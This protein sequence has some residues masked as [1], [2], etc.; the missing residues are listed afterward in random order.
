[1]DNIYLKVKKYIK[2]H[3]LVKPG[4][5]M[6]LSLSAGK[7]SMVLFHLMQ[8]L[9][10]EMGFKFSIFHLNHLVRGADSDLDQQ[11]LV[12]LAAENKVRLFCE[13][14]DFKQDT[15]KGKSF[16]EYARDIRYAQLEVLRSKHSF[17]SVATAHTQNDN[18]ETVL[19]RIFSGTGIYGLK[20][21][22]CRRDFIIRPVLCL[23]TEE[24]YEYLNYNGLKWREDLSNNDNCYLRNHIRNEILPSIVKRF[25]GAQDS[26]KSLSLLACENI[27]LLDSLAENVYKKSVSEIDSIIFIKTGILHENQP[28]FKHIIANI[29]RQKFNHN[30]NQGMLNEIC[31]NFAVIR[32]N[33]ILYRNSIFRIEKLFR[34]SS[35]LIKISSEQNEKKEIF[36]WEYRLDLKNKDSQVL[37]L[38]EINMRL[39]YKVVDY[40]FF[41]KNKFDRSYIFISIN[42]DKDSILIRNRRSGDRIILNSGS[43]KIKDLLI[44]K[45][46]DSYTKNCVPLI[47]I[48]ANI[49]AYM[50]GIISDI[51][52]RVSVNFWVNDMSKKILAISK[53]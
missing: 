6:L 30:I 37:V 4:D 21:I 46:L 33:V 24:M 3:N 43:K 25:P 7:D 32:S 8:L 27:N 28:L 45:K 47:I 18:V 5:N 13:S 34:N 48:G 42:S 35:E 49:A 20:G 15:Y 17:T 1:M 31:K 12:Q 39:K 50:P 16:E 22:S 44:E 53:N 2:E 19:M 29:I 51:S 38:K 41:V 52:N 9:K 14:H 23:T 11:F 36:D 40:C 26:V 10:D